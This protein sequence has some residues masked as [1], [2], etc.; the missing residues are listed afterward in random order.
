MAKTPK[1]LNADI[2]GALGKP[3]PKVIH[4]TDTNKFALTE[5]VIRNGGHSTFP[6]RIERVD[7]PHLRRCMAANLLIA[8]G[9]ATL[10]LTPAGIAVVLPRLHESALIARSHVDIARSRGPSYKREEDRATERLRQIN[11]AISTLQGGG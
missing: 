8:N 9:R 3:E 7:A 11:A 2:A 1:Q 5:L 4:P 10:S 6:N